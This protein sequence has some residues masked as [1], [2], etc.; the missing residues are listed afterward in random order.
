IISDGAITGLQ[1]IKTPSYIQIAG[2]TDQA[3]VTITGA[4]LPL[5]P[6]VCD[7]DSGGQ[8]GEGNPTRGLVYTNRFSAGGKNATFIQAQHWSL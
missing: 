3:K 1:F 2:T 6:T 7:L 8:D 5:I 4:F